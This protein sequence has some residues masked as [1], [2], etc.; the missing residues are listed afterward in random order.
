VLEGSVVWA[1][2][3]AIFVPRGT[4]PYSRKG[5]IRRFRPGS[6][7][8]EGVYHF[9]PGSCS[10]TVSSAPGTG[11]APTINRKAYCTI[12]SCSRDSK[13]GSN[14]GLSTNE[15]GASHEALEARL[16]ETHGF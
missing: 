2:S 14:F 4:K 13:R 9:Q 10:M 6:I 15:A 12:S 3:L 16:P 11:D 8:G 7:T 5:A 1:M